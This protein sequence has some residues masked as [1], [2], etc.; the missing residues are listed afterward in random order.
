M[1][2]AFC[3]LKSYRPPTVVGIVPFASYSHTT[4]RKKAREDDDQYMLQQQSFSRIQSAV[5]FFMSF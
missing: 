2:H 3:I 4:L 1:T 5:F